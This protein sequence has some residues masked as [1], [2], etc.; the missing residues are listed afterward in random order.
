MGIIINTTSRNSFYNR[1]LRGVP[2]VTSRQNL[3][4]IKTLVY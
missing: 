3:S 4:K 1:V 2:S